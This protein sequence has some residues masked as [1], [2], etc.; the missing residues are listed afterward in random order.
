MDKL[1]L[2]FTDNITV[3]YLFENIKISM[4]TVSLKCSPKQIKGDRRNQ[5]TK[6]LI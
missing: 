1:Q 6:F 3:D 2:K 4:K 5:R